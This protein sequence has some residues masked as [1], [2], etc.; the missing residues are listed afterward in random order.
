MMAKSTYQGSGTNMYISLTDIEA[1]Y[2]RALLSVDRVNIS[3]GPDT[4]D[5][6]SFLVHSI[7]DL[8]NRL[9]PDA[10]ESK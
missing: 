8:I 2:L 1:G 3:K 5:S 4:S 9:T 7:T 6:A 10:K